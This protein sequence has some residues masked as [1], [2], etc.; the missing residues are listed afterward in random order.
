MA[1]SKKYFHDHLVLLLLSIQG[2][3]AVAGSIFVL[4]R[5]SNNHS[6]GHIVAYRPS[7]GVNAYQPGSVT[8]LLSFTGFALLVLLIHTTLSM[9]TYNIHRQLSISIL[10]LGILLLVLNVIVSN[11]LLLLG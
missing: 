8:E 5:L 7:L 9:R 1:T 2:F 10:S 3:L 11:A 6:A 4:L